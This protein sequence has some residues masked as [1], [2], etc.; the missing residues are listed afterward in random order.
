MGANDATL[1]LLIAFVPSLIVFFSPP[2]KVWYAFVFDTAFAF[3]GAF[4]VV[5][6]AGVGDVSFFFGVG[7]GVALFVFVLDGLGV[8][9]GVG[10]DAFFMSDAAFFPI[11]LDCP[12]MSRLSP[13]SFGNVL[14]TGG[15]GA[16]FAIAEL[17]GTLC[18]SAS[19]CKSAVAAR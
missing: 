16:L 5:T 2:T 8:G 14:F 10:V 1:V 11:R 7:C 6:G 19:F 17:R 15:L 12:V 13:K 3:T 4:P 18:L 9:L